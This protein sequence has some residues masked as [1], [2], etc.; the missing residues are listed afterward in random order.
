VSGEI[1]GF[2][3]AGRARR[4]EAGAA[5]EVFVIH[6]LPAWRARGVGSALWSAACAR[7]R[8]PV[9]S[10]MY[11]DTL[12]ELACCSFYAAHGGQRTER[13]PID[14]HG[15][16]RTHVTYVWPERHGHDF[17]GRSGD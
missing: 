11:V 5:T 9:L 10:S 13:R 4:A 8:G 17:R 7:V 1:I 16:T 12:E 14:F 3:H 6:V 15:A 2:V